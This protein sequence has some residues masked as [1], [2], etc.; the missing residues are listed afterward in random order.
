MQFMAVGALAMENRS[1]VAAA[2]QSFAD[3]APAFVANIQH[4][5]FLSR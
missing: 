3:T 4:N 1:P 5:D 2:Q